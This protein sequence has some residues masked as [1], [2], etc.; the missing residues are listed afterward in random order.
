LRT[1]LRLGLGSDRIAGAALRIATNALRDDRRGGAE[2]AYAVAS[3]VAK[4][5]PNW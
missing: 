5:A 4:F 2:R 3:A 1:A